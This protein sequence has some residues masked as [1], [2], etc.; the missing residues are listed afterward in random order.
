MGK[1][2]VWPIWKYESPKL[3]NG[4]PLTFALTDNLFIACLSDNPSDIFIFLDTYDDHLPS[5]NDLKT[6]TQP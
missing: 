5:L 6:E 4:T 1:H 2:S 3:A